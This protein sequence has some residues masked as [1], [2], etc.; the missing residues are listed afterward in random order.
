[1]PYNPLEWRDGPEGETPITA[2]ALNRMEQ[3]IKEAHDTLDSHIQDG[4]AHGANVS[5]VP[6]AIVRRD[7]QGRA[8][9]ANPSAA[10][11]AANKAY[12]DNSVNNHAAAQSNVHGVPNGGYFW[13]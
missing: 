2:A 1:M 3:G 11:D 12:V 7:S 13:H 4:G 8:Q 9:F 5:A 10:Q 6:D